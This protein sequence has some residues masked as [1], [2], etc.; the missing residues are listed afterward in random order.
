MSSPKKK[1]KRENGTGNKRAELKSAPPQ[2]DNS[3]LVIRV[4]KHEVKK[5]LEYFKFLKQFYGRAEVALIFAPAGIYCQGQGTPSTSLASSIIT[6]SDGDASSQNIQKQEQ[7]YHYAFEA[8]MN[9]TF[10]THYHCAK[11]W[12]RLLDIYQVCDIVRQ[13]QAVHP[14]LTY[15]EIRK[16]DRNMLRVS[17]DEESSIVHLATYEPGEMHDAILGCGGEPGIDDAVRTRLDSVEWGARIELDAAHVKRTFQK[18]FECDVENIFVAYRAHSHLLF[19]WNQSDIPQR[20]ERFSLV[21]I[22]NDA[23]G[24]RVEERE[25][26]ENESFQYGNW[27]AKALLAPICTASLSDTIEMYMETKEQSPQMLLLQMRVEDDVETMKERDA[28]LVRMWIAP[29]H[30]V[31]PKQT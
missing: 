17:D 19:R 9:K 13:I 25:G 6:D 8:R 7:Q 18:M 29:K 23:K 4:Y 27:F 2:H 20:Q 11:E 5:L 15:I 24:K 14:S 16:E 30:I 3:D 1:Q 21:S 12:K 10:V 31:V 26:G 22:G 28:T